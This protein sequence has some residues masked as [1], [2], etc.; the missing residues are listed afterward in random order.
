MM[1]PMDFERMGLLLIKRGDPKRNHNDQRVFASHFGTD[2]DT[3]ADAWSLLIASD[4]VQDHDNNPKPEHLFFGLYSLKINKSEHVSCKFFQVDEKTYRKW[5]WFIID[6]LS[7]LQ[8]R[9]VSTSTFN[10]HFFNNGIFLHHFFRLNGIAD[11]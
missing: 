2:H 11:L 7:Q 10:N 9:V 6:S 8:F 3:C 5:S 1:L 4:Y